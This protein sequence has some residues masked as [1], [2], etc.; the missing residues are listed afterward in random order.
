M[1]GNRIGIDLFGRIA[2]VGHPISP[3][4]FSSDPFRGKVPNCPGSQQQV[5]STPECKQHRNAD[6]PGNALIATDI[7]A[8][9]ADQERSEEHTS[10]LQSLMRISY[11]VFCL[12]KKKIKNK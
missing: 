4:I 5:D 6:A 3:G 9:R 12:N 2:N 1:R 11:A 10:E 7:V 8:D